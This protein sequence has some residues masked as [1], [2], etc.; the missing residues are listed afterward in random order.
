MDL[1]VAGIVTIIGT[2]LS[3]ALLAWASRKW[4]LP[5]LARQVDSQQAALID[6]LQTRLTLVEA[7]AKR[8]NTKA[9][10]T[11]KRRQACEAAIGRLRRRLLLTERE[12]LD[13][14]RETGKTPPVR[15]ETHED[16]YLDVTEDD[17]EEPNGD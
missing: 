8:A 5:G 11:E 3:T 9:T 6:T 10:R 17:D 13:L 1:I 2:V 12:L 16:E 7:D 4:G 14:Y 15:L